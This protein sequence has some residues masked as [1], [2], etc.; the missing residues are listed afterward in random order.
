MS[1]PN[2]YEPPREPEPLTR[3]KVVKRS[4]GVAS[5]ILLTP[6]AM[7]VAA[8]ISCSLGDSPALRGNGQT[9]VWLVWFGG[10]L[11]VLT[12]L[13]AWAAA[14]H[15]PRQGERFVMP[16]R[17]GLLLATPI[18]TGV[19]MAVGFGLATLAVDVTGRAAGGLTA[20][21]VSA[22]LVLFFVVPSA[23]LLGML[24]LAWRAGEN[25]GE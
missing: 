16:W 8:V 22:G 3:G 7:I 14:L 6:P 4:V 21:G 5:I 25:S 18:V 17:V 9:I 15:R 23:A 24:W 13:M 2:P 11:L 12:A 10:P 1:N 20:T 19:A